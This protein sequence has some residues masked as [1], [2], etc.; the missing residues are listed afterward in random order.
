MVKP[1]DII[2][3][4]A[5]T[6]ALV[7]N[8]VYNLTTNTQIPSSWG[9]SPSG[10][11]TYTKYSYMSAV[12]SA[13]VPAWRPTD[14]RW[15]PKDADPARSWELVGRHSLSY[16]G[17]FALNTSVAN[18]KTEGQLLH[19]PIQTASVPVMINETQARYYT[20]VERGKEVFLNVWLESQGLR[21]E[22]WWRRVMKG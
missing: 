18:T 20:V 22:I 3:A 11:L 2:N 1:S 17:T 13:T 19:G 12:M 5:G 6:Y 9:D 14:I 7:N 15:P 4:L 8:T 21:S 16:A 10:L